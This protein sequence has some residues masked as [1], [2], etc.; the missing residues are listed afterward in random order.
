MEA[1]LKHWLGCVHTLT[2]GP[3]SLIYFKTLKEGCSTQEKEVEEDLT[4]DLKCVEIK[5]KQFLIYMSSRYRDTSSF[6]TV[7]WLM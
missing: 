3:V 7:T 5:F 1:Y 4:Q 6:I 2:F